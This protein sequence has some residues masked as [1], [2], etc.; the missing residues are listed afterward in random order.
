ML[1]EVI[2]NNIDVLLISETKLDALFPSSQFI[3]DGFTP[4]YRLDKTQHGGGIMFFIREGITSKLLN[5]DTSFEIESLL[6]EISLRSKKW[7]IS[8]SYSPHLN[9]IQNHLVQLSKKFVF[10]SSKYENFIVLG[11]FNAEMTNTNMEEFSSV[12]NFKSLIK[13]PTCFKNPEKPTTIDHIL[14]NHPKCFQHSGVSFHSKFHSIPNRI[15]NSYNTK[16]FTNEN[17]RR[18]LLRELSFQNVQPNE[19]DKFKF[20]ASKLLNSHAPLKKKYIRC[21]QAV[22][23]NKQLRIIINFYNNLNVKKVT[24]NKHF[25]KKIKPNFTEKVLKDERIVLVEDDKVITADIDLTEIFKDHFENIVERLHIERPCKVDFDREPVANAIKNVSQHPSILKIKE[26]TNFSA[27]FSF[28]TVS[29]ENLLYQLNNLN[30]TKAT[31][32]SD[33]PT[34]IIKK[35]YDIFSEF[36]FENFNNIILTSLFPEQLKD[37]DVKPIFKKDS[38]NDKTNYRPVSILSNISKKYDRLLYKQLETY[39]ESILSRYQC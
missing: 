9:S 4:P 38:R 8:G 25:W 39:F 14:A 16:I 19:F 31:Q 26:N 32:K 37:A 30:P 5:A 34:N 33:I 2:G 36:L 20:I 12:H 15:P 7:L 6:V 17:F 18:D 11:D 23:M 13:D 1:Q 10:Y 24:D 3:L 29:K 22:F 27:C 21:N 35:N 28:R